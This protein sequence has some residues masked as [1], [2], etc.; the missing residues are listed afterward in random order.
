VSAAAEHQSAQAATA[1]AAQ[2]LADLEARIDAG[3]GRVTSAQLAAAEADLALANRREAAANARAVVQAEEL[4]AERAQAAIAKA[5]ADYRAGADA[6]RVA[7]GTALESLAGVLEAGDVHMRTT[8]ANAAAVG[9]YGGTLNRHYAAPTTTELLDGLVVAARTA[10]G[11]P[12][13]IPFPH[14][15]LERV[16]DYL[17]A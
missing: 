16:R 12:V 11:T 2:A 14:L 17:P 13:D 3:D 1:K 4:E 5:E 6:L 8:R 9:A 10:A 15:T 7:V